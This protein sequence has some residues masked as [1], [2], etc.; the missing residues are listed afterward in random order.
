MTSTSERYVVQ[1][2]RPILD[3]IPNGSE[4]PNSEQLRAVY[5]GLEYFLPE[6]LREIHGE[7]MNES[8]DGV[9]PYSRRKSGDAEADINGHVILIS[10]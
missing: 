9:L 10:D 6:L 5:S 3:A 2:P 8:L 4:M 1:S 7:W